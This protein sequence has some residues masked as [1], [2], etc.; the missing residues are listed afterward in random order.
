M[1]APPQGKRA[2]GLMPAGVRTRRAGGDEPRRSL[3]CFDQRSLVRCGFGR[4]DV[5]ATPFLIEVHF[6]FDQREDRVVAA[7]ADVAAGAPARA[8]LADDD[9]PRNDSLATP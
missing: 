4:L 5:D 7:E 6:A 2:A 3:F 9:I 8:A 1:S